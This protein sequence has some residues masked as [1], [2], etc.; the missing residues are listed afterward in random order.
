LIAAGKKALKGIITRGHSEAGKCE[1]GDLVNTFNV[2]D[3]AIPTGK[4]TVK[5][6]SSD[7]ETVAST[8]ITVAE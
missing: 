1:D 7:G 6:V 8:V 5:F 2:D 3:A 4:H